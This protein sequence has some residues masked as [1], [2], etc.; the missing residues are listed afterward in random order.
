MIV[1]VQDDGAPKVLNEETLT[2]TYQ[3][4]QELLWNVLKHAPTMEATCPC[5]GR[6]TT[7]KRLEWT[8]G[9]GFERSATRRSSAEGIFVPF[10][11]RERV[12]PLAGRLE[13]DSR[14]GH[15]T[16]AKLIIP[17]KA[18]RSAIRSP[19]AIQEAPPAPL[20][21]RGREAPARAG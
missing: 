9:M 7:L 6:G 5:D 14:P 11:M 15:G 18:E 1:T 12:E 17:L 13:I 21:A 20:A 3:S 10:N 19:A 8:R 4:I 16:S 2:I